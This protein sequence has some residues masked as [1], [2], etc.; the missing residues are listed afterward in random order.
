M[1]NKECVD[2]KTRI[3]KHCKNLILDKVT[4]LE[5]E[6]KYLHYDIA[7]DNKSSAGDK[8]EVSR[9]LANAEVEKLQVQVYQMNQSVTILNTLPQESKKLVA[10]GSLI[11]TDNSWLFVSV[12]LGEIVVD[13]QKILVMSPGAPLAKGFIGK[14]TGD[15]VI[16]NKTEYKIREIY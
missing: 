14:S 6:L 15:K 7:E 11:K 9:E 10:Q 16:F 5:K 2:F 12:S 8:F 1:E 3:I 13:K 4:I